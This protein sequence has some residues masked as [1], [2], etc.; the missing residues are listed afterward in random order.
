MLLIKIFKKRV[1][2]DNHASKKANHK[3]KMSK[4]KIRTLVNLILLNLFY[5]CNYSNLKKVRANY[6]SRN[7]KRLNKTRRCNKN[8]LNYTFKTSKL[9]MA[10]EEFQIKIYYRIIKMLLIVQAYNCNKISLQLP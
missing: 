8:N 1:W 6:Y 2:R 9:Q 3:M 10:K 7:H 4:K 5:R